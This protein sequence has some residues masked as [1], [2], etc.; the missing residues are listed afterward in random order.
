MLGIKNQ[1]FYSNKQAFEQLSKINSFRNYIKNHSMQ[2]AS[3]NIG[4]RL[5]HVSSRSQERGL[6]SAPEPYHPVGND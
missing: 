3:Q 6:K 2:H 5:G 1:Q 4:T